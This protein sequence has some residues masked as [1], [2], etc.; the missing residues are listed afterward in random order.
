SSRDPAVM[1]EDSTARSL[2]SGSS[3]DAVDIE[4]Y[5]RG[6]GRRRP[7][8]RIV[9]PRLAEVVGPHVQTPLTQYFAQSP[10]VAVAAGRDGRLQLL[11][12]DDAVAVL[13]HLAMGGAAGT[14]N[15]AGPGTMT[16]TQAIH[17]A[18]RI[19]VPVPALA[20]D[21]VGALLR[22]GRIP[23][24]AETVRLL[25]PGR[26]MDT[27]RLVNRFHFTPAYSTVAAFD[28]FVGRLRPAV[29]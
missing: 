17:R 8:V 4:G 14:V 19:P 27:S 13:E 1:T 24:S 11:H 2:P 6:F 15:V 18:G 10:F 5:V 23:F 12:E 28:D 21:G 16:V 20:L 3:R 26:V 25:S 9:V 22:L 7:D 29:P